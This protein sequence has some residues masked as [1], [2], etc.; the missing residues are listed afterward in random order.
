MGPKP[1]SQ[2][3]TTSFVSVEDLVKDWDERFKEQASKTDTLQEQ[4]QVMMEQMRVILDNQERYQGVIPGRPN[5]RNGHG[6]RNYGQ[7][8][9]QE[10]QRQFQYTKMEFTKFT[11]DDVKA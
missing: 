10:R 5:G 6:D 2:S 7:N 8:V 3:S 1:Q 4:I 11:A 9:N